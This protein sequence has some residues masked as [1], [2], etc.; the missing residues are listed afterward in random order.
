MPGDEDVV[1]LIQQIVQNA[2]ACMERERAVTQALERWHEWRLQVEGEL[3]EAERALA[4]FVK[5][6]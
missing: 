1:R 6:R 5:D 4:E 2:H 3:S